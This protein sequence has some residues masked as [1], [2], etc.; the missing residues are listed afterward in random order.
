MTRNRQ[1]DI[2]KQLCDALGIEAILEALPQHK[3]KDSL[4]LVSIKEVANQL[5][6]PYETLRSRMVSGQIPFPE[7]RLGRRAYFTQDQAEK[8]TCPCNEQ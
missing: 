2:C 1:H 6:M 8:I 3:I 5:N 7:M 4:G